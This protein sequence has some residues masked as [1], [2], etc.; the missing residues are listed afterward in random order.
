MC[1]AF[2][3]GRC[4]QKCICLHTQPWGGCGRPFSGAKLARAHGDPFISSLVF[5]GRQLK[6]H[7]ADPRVGVLW[8]T[9]WVDLPAPGLLVLRPPGSDPCARGSLMPLGASE[10]LQ[11]VV[12]GLL[13]FLAWAHGD[14]CER[15]GFSSPPAGFPTPLL[16][17]Q[18]TLS[19]PLSCFPPLALMYFSVI[20]PFILL[21]PNFFLFLAS[22]RHYYL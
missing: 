5:G 6:A 11:T 20:F 16:S 22:N 4:V 13:L 12:L 14:M 21:S 9:T 2:A 8:N 3:H 7:E 18:L 1:W 10:G 19:L 15:S 17:F